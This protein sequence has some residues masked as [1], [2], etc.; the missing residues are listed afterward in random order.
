[1]TFCIE[2]ELMEMTPEAE[3]TSYADQTRD[4]TVLDGVPYRTYKL[5]FFDAR[6]GSPYM[7]DIVNRIF[8]CDTVSIEGKG[9]VRNNGAKLNVN[10]VKGYPLV[11]GN[12]E[13]TEAKNLYSL[14][15]NDLSELAP[16]I[17]TAY[18]IDANWFGGSSI[19][20]ITEIDSP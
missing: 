10:R 3:I 19:V 13:V 15:H 8:C 16:G 5:E 11:G 12:I 9:Y 14:Q 17:V 6:G 2:C 20:Q 18:N 7:L 4:I 1:M